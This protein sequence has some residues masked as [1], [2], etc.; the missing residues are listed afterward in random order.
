MIISIKLLSIDKQ[1]ERKIERKRDRERKR[2]GESE[3]EREIY[4]KN[5][6]IDRYEYTNIYMNKHV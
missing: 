6:P 4:K 3:S 5:T 1:I 2:D